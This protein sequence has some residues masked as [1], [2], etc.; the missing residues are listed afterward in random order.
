MTISIVSLRSLFVSIGMIH[1]STA[2]LGTLVSLRIADSG[3]SQEAASF[4]AASYS[5]GFLL[6]CFFIFRPLARIGHIRAFA[7]SAA[8]CSLCALLLSISENTLVLIAARFATGLATASLYSIGDAW[9]ND[10]APANSRGRILSIY[11][12]V[13]GVTS[14]A[15][16]AF[17]ILFSGDLSEAFVMMSALYSIA[18]IVLVPTRTSPPSVPAHAQL[19]LIASFRESPTSFIGVFVNGFVL[20]LLLTVLP[21]QAS[22]AGM[23]AN[24]IAFVVA[25]FYLGRILFQFPIGHASDRMDRRYMIAAMSLSAA[26]TVMILS[27]ASRNEGFT[28]AGESGLVLQ[29][30]MIIGSVFLGGLIMPLYSVLVA[31]AMDRTVPVYVGATAVTLL[32]VYTVGSVVGPIFGGIGS[33]LGS[34]RAVQWMCWVLMLV[35]GMFTVVR[36]KMRES[37]PHAEAA[38]GVAASPTSVSISP[39]TKRPEHSRF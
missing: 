5:M 18:I 22:V 38:S 2:A 9:I 24:M 29:V 23:S 13:L 16:Q 12:I 35:A 3:G 1:L 10:S 34:D 28:I 36:I 37:A 4:V 31:H 7:A 25:A 27:I 33:L 11:Y 6:G 8:L 30:V 20:A 21:Y 14:V 26:L 15:S 32:F 39:E 19:R 17:I